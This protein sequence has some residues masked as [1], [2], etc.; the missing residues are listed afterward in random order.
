MKSRF[1]KKRNDNNNNK[2]MHTNL[3]ENR[4]DSEVHIADI[5]KSQEACNENM[6]FYRI[7]FITL[8]NSC[9]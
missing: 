5:S 4:D 6:K 3:I 7:L 9:T 2:R 8:L 1:N